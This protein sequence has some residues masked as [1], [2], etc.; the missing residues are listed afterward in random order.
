MQSGS[1]LRTLSLC[2]S[3][4]QNL[5]ARLAMEGG[6]AD[7][8]QLLGSQCLFLSSAGVTAACTASCC[9][10]RVS[11]KGQMQEEELCTK[12]TLSVALAHSP[13]ASVQGKQGSSAPVG[14][15]QGRM[16]LQAE[17]TPQ[18]WWLLSPRAHSSWAITELFL[19]ALICNSFFEEWRK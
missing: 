13:S 3:D 11:V 17:I 14:C 1:C 19:G 5:E 2:W 15:S 8:T 9:K 18:P 4:G 12:H 16:E 7:L 6:T 10:N